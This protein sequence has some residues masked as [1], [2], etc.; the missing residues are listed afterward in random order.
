M[1]VGGVGLD[2]GKR[3]HHTDSG[4]ASVDNLDKLVARFERGE[5][6]LV[7]VGRSLL[8]DADWVGKAIRGEP[9]LPFDR[10]ALER[11]T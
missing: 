4:S 11:L 10:A 8:N 2:Q 7:G 5:F 9:F 3:A 1:V 6:D